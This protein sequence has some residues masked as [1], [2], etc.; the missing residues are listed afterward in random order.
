MTDTSAIAATVVLLLCIAVLDATFG[1]NGGL[2]NGCVIGM[3]FGSL[4]ERRIA[5]KD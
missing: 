4:I 1:G 5:R 2:F 3:F